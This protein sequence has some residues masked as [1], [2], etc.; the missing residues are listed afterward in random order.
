MENNTVRC[1]VCNEPLR[2]RVTRGRK[3]GKPSIMFICPGDGRHF[4][5]FVTYLPYVEQVL[6]QTIQGNAR[7]S[8]K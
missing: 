6:N 1:L 8:G 7:G 5:G 4:R 2:L 3:S